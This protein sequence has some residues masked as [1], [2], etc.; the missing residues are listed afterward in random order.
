[1]KSLGNKILNSVENKLKIKT[2][3][4]D[5]TTEN[6]INKKFSTENRNDKEKRK[7]KVNPKEK[8]IKT[9]KCCN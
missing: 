6:F 4:F 8:T 1:M 2:N 9:N 7:R 5:R 3:N